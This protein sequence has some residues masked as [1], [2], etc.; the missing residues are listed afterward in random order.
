MPV[1]I[2]QKIFDAQDLMSLVGLQE[3]QVIG[4]LG[5][6]S[7][8]F[9]TVPFAER[10]GQTG[11]VYAVDV[12]Q[13]A[14]DATAKAARRRNIINIKLVKANLEKFGSTEIPP[15][16][17]DLAFLIS[18]LFQNSDWRTII[19]EA[20]RLVRAD[21]RIVVVDWAGDWKGFGPPAKIRVNPAEVK[22]TALSLGYQTAWEGVVGDYH[23]G[24]IFKKI[25]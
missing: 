20:D 24:L 23:F 10:I 11:K 12:L 17:L 3:G 21:G 25:K 9:F 13:E 1:S 15:K 22:E 6:G 7:G 18:V 19:K 4:H 2:N 5:C 16:S 14:L 8:S